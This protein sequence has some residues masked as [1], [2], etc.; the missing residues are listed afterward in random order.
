MF[1]VTES[2]DYEVIK[3]IFREYSNT[4]GAERCFVSLEKE[5]NDLDSY[6]EGGAVLLGFE[7]GIPAGS[8]AIRRIDDDYCEGKRLYI[9]P[10]FRGRGYARIM[11]ERMTDKA[12]E[13]GFKEVRFTTI[14]GVMSVA[15]EWYKRIG[16]E[17]TGRKDGIVGMKI[18]LV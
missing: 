17:E 8:V 3:E 13:L 6:Y 12:K 11:L 16:Y 1:E 2:K 18:R 7:D 10:A 4:K 15:Y 9:R 14:P 5:L